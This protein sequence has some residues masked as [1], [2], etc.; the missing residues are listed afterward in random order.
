M[1]RSA[2][3][4]ST[5]GAPALFG[6]TS[7]SRSLG[8]FFQLRLENQNDKKY[9][10]FDKALFTN[11]GNIEFIECAYDLKSYLLSQTISTTTNG[12]ITIIYYVYKHHQAFSFD[13]CDR[14]FS[15]KGLVHRI[16]FFQ[17]FV[18]VYERHLWIMRYMSIAYRR[19]WL[20]W[21]EGRPKRNIGFVG[22][23]R[24]GFQFLYFF[25]NRP[26]EK[27]W[28]MLRCTALRHATLRCVARHV[29]CVHVLWK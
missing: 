24:V 7:R 16:F 17:S 9:D 29:C 2:G 11:N 18:Y 5:A 14:I 25:E 21:P 28:I 23:L 12:Q 3:G 13:A 19:R 26:T 15:R 27:D 4:R 6:Q 22:F 20:R 8:H 10:N 1:R